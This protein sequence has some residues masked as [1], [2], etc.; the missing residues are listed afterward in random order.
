MSAQHG[1][2]AGGAHDGEPDWFKGLD[3]AVWI[4]AGVVLVLA[5]EWLIGRYMR[6]SISRGAQQFLAK[7]TAKG[8]GEPEV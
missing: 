7:T 3:I 8:G 1:R 6:E 5:A 4:A 2:P